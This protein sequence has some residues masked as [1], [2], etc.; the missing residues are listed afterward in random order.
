MKC[1]VCRS[2]ENRSGEVVSM[3]V[4]LHDY[5][6][7]QMENLSEVAIVVVLEGLGASEGLATVYENRVT[8]QTWIN[9]DALRELA[10][11]QAQTD[12][13]NGYIS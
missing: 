6:P 10:R 3:F 12:G 2:I 9:Q 7:I 1:A 13:R 4:E 8:R 5:T 11:K